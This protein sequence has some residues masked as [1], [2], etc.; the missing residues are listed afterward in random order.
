[1]KIRQMHQK[2]ERNFFVFQIVA[3]ELR[4]GNSH[5]LEQ[6]T[7]R[8]AVNVLTNIPKISPNTRGGIF[9]INSP[10]NDKGT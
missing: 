8:Q 10:E 2:I 4:V 5:N 1:M 6:D 9:Q 7:C 3:F